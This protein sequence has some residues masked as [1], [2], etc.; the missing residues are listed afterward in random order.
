MLTPTDLA[1]AG[2]RT[3]VDNNGCLYISVPIDA[4]R[5]IGIDTDE[6]S[7]QDLAAELHT[8]GEFR[9]CVDPGRPK[10]QS[11]SLKESNSADNDD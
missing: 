2:T 10:P 1:W 3:I 6:I 8:D 9:I 4:L 5:D 11:E 7:G